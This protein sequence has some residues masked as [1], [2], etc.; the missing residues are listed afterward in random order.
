M[1]G[2]PFDGYA[3]H[4]RVCIQSRT[5]EVFPLWMDPSTGPGHMDRPFVEEATVKLN[6]GGVPILT[7]KLTPPYEDAVRFLD[8]ALVEYA[9]DGIL[10][11]RM[12]Y[13][14]P[15]GT[16][17]LSPIYEGLLLKPD[18]QV[19][20]DISIT[21]NAQGLPRFNPASDG[22][23]VRRRGSRRDIVE[24]LLRG[25]DPSNPGRLTLDDSEVAA[26][27]SSNDAYR[28]FF[29]TP[30]D[31]QQSG[32]TDWQ[33]LQ[34][35]VWESRCWPVLVSETLRDNARLKIVP[36]S[37]L[38]TQ[39]PSRTFR[40]FNHPASGY[41]D[42]KEYP[43]FSASSPSLGVYLSDRSIRGI[44]QTGLDRNTRRPTSEVTTDAT[45]A[46]ARRGDRS[47]TAPPDDL[48]PGP[49]SDGRQGYVMLA[50]DP[51]DPAAVARAQAQFDFMTTQAGVKLTL[52]T[53]G[54]PDLSPGEVVFVTGLGRRLV[55][56]TGYL[57]TELTHTRGGGGYTTSMEVI[58]N[59]AN[60]LADAE[61][62]YGQAAQPASP[63]APQGTGSETQ[64]ARVQ[65]PARRGR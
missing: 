1:S 34:Q 46:P 63:S 29:A 54:I 28:L 11:V 22:A 40:F 23:T 53:L 3:P 25:P 36:R 19:G 48:H 14:P 13:V 55:S 47:Q 32:R 4:L 45:A 20:E 56:P 9:N 35:L 37:I 7:V 15:S 30:L 51:K 61:R 60:A 5:G 18:I 17:V 59:T 62:A 31:L 8:S 58:S 2:I 38:A 64:T 6:L 43:L 49:S 21:L 12:G 50:G 42:G 57:I 16:A 41:S 10:Q 52:E 44:R 27:G 24:A 26:L 33:L 65:T 39:G